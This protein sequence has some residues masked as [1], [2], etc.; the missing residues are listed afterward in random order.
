MEIHQPADSLDPSQYVSSINTLTG[1]VILAA[2]TNITLGT[3]GN[4]ITINATG[5]SP[6]LTDTHIF[7]GNA[8]NVATDVALTLS[9][10]GGT[11][12]LANTGILTMPNATTSI[13]GLLTSTDWNTF[14]NKLSSVLTDSHIL[15]GDGTNVAT[16]VAVSGD[17]TLAN[18]GAF[19]IANN[20]VTY[21]K[22]QAVGALSRLLGSSS[23]STTVQE[24]TLGSGLSMSGTTLTSTGLGGTVTSVA[25]LLPTSE[26]SIAGSP[27]TSSGTLTGSWISQ[28]ANR[29]FVAPDGSNGI[30]SFRAM[31]RRD[32]LPVLDTQDLLNISNIVQVNNNITI[33]RAHTTVTEIFLTTSNGA[34]VVSLELPNLTTVTYGVTIETRDLTNLDLSALTTVGSEFA[35]NRVNTSTLSLASLTSI[36]SS[37]NIAQN[38]FTSINLSGLAGFSVTLSITENPN[39]TSVNIQSVVTSNGGTMSISQNPVLDTI[40]IN[41]SSLDCLDINFSANALTQTN[42]DDILIYVDAAGFSNGNLDLSGGTNSTP[43]GGV[44][45]A[46]YL[47][48]LGKGWTVSIN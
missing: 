36:G 5:S 16:D 2:G 41:T 42:V 39:L 24:I 30:P 22:M 44:G 20:A 18:T 6:A 7:V 45:N 10:T 38:Q 19:T 37:I 1:A 11:F 15:V 26:F 17:L 23:V 21:T 35:V 32:L 29:M 33:N 12:S 3:V 9:A 4:T 48:L 34:G 47:S 46:E 43:T 13:R 27:V 14:N 25:L 28:T 8:L 40:D 31:A